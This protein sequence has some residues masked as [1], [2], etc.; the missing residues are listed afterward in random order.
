MVSRKENQKVDYSIM[1]SRCCPK[2]GRPL[3]KNSELKGHKLC[4]VCYKLSKGK[5]KIGGVDLVQK[6]K[7]N[8]R[9]YKR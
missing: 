5:T 2:C 3:K 4:Y 6:Q 1:S 7:E 9:K 8:I